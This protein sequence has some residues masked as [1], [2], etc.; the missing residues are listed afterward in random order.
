[1][2]EVKIEEKKLNLKK[3]QLYQETPKISLFMGEEIK[4]VQSIKEYMDEDTTFIEYF[5][6]KD[7]IFIWVISRSDMHFSMQKVSNSELTYLIDKHV[8]AITYNISELETDSAKELYDLLIAPVRSHIRT[9]K[10]GIIPHSTLHYV[11][12]HALKI[13]DR[14]LIEDFSIFYLPSAG[15]NKY[16]NKYEQGRGLEKGRVKASLSGKF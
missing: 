6:G 3:D 13:N 14:Y 11:P 16:L 5:L 9:F 10:V 15:I 4:D 1:M 7:K 8:K 2:R 12:F